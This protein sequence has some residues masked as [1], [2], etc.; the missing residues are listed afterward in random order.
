MLLAKKTEA[1]IYFDGWGEPFNQLQPIKQKYYSWGGDTDWCKNDLENLKK[2]R[3]EFESGF[4]N[5]FVA[6][7]FEKYLANTAEDWEQHISGI[8]ELYWRDVDM[9]RETAFRMDC[10]GVDKLSDYNLINAKYESEFGS[11]EFWEEV[12]SVKLRGMNREIEVISPYMKIWIFPPKSFIIYEMKKAMK[13]HEFPGPSE[14]K[15]ER[16]KEEGMTAEEKNKIRQDKGFMDK[17]KE[18]SGKY[19]GSMDVVIQFKDYEKKRGC[20]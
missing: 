1:F 19:E 18:V 6:W 5:E 7:F 16:E 10:A 14:N 11:M 2:Q 8:F 3:K 15:M 4:N 9:S 17:I 20:F 12:K 13:E